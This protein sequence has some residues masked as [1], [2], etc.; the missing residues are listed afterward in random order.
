MIFGVDFDGTLS[1]GQ[2]PD[3][4]TPNMGLIDFLKK[5]R[6]SGDKLILWTVVREIVLELPL[7]GVVPTNC[8]S[9]Q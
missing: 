6:Q 1:F 8:N 3:T 4:G 2:W 9:M 5:R 7:I